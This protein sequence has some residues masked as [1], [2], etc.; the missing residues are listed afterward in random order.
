MD[1]MK[2]ITFS[3]L[4]YTTRNPFDYST[5]TRVGPSE[6]NTAFT[7]ATECRFFFVGATV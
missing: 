1:R 6:A 7:S 3:T 2:Y 4:F 5:I